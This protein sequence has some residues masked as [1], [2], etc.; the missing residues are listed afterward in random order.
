M[1]VLLTRVVMCCLVMV[2]TPEVRAQTETP[3]PAVSAP[4]N[5]TVL[6]GAPPAS[7]VVWNRTLAVFRATIGSATPALR[8]EA[9]S[10]RIES[11][12]DRLEPAGISYSIAQL[13]SERAAVIF[14]AGALFAIL[15]GDLPQDGADSLET[16]GAQAASRL[17][18]LLR[19]HQEETRWRV[20][21]RNAIQALLATVAFVAI[22]LAGRGAHQWLMAR[23]TRLTTAWIKANGYRRNRSAARF[24]RRSRVADL[25]GR[26]RRE[27]R[28]GLHLADL[29][30]LALR[31]FQAMGPHA[32]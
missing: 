21:L 4:P 23:L 24:G 10:A 26:I 8:A 29:R 18:L 5:Q 6:L 7:L 32:R 13:G 28:G 11:A 25:G 20:I 27:T 16:A 22:W 19:E 17:Q 2:W 31:V 30:S 14:G 15:E 1:R 9:A 3:P 12:F